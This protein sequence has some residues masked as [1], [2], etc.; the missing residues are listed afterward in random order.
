M[1]S[2]LMD[3]AYVPMAGKGL[4]VSSAAVKYGKLRMEQPSL[5]PFLKPNSHNLVIVV[6]VYDS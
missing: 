5:P 6:A 1:D 3:S 2:A 4:P